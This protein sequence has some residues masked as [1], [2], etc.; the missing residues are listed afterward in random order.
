MIYIDIELISYLDVSCLSDKVIC[1][2]EDKWIQK[3]NE[4]VMII[5][6]FR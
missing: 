4:L 3:L 6:I 2:D 5:L 1:F